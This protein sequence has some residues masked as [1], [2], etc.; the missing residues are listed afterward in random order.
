[1]FII[2]SFKQIHSYEE[3]LKCKPKHGMLAKY[4]RK[5]YD[6]E[7]HEG[8]I[9]FHLNAGWAVTSKG[10]RW[11]EVSVEHWHGWYINMGAHEANSFDYQYEAFWLDT[12]TRKIGVFKCPE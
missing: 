9:W 12:G 4:I 3:F 6:G 8:A 2:M 1:M 7:V 11:K 5:G 10:M